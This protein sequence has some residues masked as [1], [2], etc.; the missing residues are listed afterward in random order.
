[1]PSP[2]ATPPEPLRA[3]TRPLHRR[4]RVWL[5][6]IALFALGA[7]GGTSAGEDAAAGTPSPKVT[8]TATATATAMVTETASPEPRATVTKTVKAQAPTP[9]PSRRT[10]APAA[11]SPTAK[12]PAEKCSI[13]SNSGNCYR[14]GQFCRNSDHGAATTTASGQRITCRLSSNAWRWVYS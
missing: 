7:L 10:T 3:D 12:A 1:M 14:A 13:L 8:V 5:G 11:P 4:K 6:G 9:T 2:N